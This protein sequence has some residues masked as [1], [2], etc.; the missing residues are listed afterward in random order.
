MR[1]VVCWWS[2][3]EDMVA[4]VRLLKR[5]LQETEDEQYKVTLLDFCLMCTGQ[6]PG[7]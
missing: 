4:Q 6:C 1:D 5:R 7:P 3:Q 2:E